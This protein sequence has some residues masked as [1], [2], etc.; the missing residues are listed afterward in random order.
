MAT[1]EKNTAR[2]LPFPLPPQKAG[3]KEGIQ[4]T[5]LYQIKSQKSSFIHIPKHAS[6]EFD[7]SSSRRQFTFT[8][9]YISRDRQTVFIVAEKVY[10]CNQDTD[11]KYSTLASLAGQPIHFIPY[12]IIAC[13]IILYHI[14]LSILSINQSKSA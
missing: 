8:K 7:P 10:P 4:Y 3:S 9:I 2:F 1:K 13:H 11:L 5:I 6:R 14:Y 12:H